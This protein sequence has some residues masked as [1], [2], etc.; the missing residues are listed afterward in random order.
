MDKIKN[1]SIY[2]L[3]SIGLAIF[4]ITIAVHMEAME[5]KVMTEVQLVGVQLDMEGFL[6]HKTVKEIIKQRGFQK[7]NFTERRA[8]NIN[9]N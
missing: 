9:L 4:Y 2:F 1:A 6:Y 8:G 5:R 7:N 3:S